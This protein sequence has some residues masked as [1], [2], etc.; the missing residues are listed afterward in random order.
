MCGGRGTRLGTETEKPLYPVRGRPM[1]DSVLG[2]LRESTIDDF[3]AVTS[4][5][6]P[7]TAAHVDCPTIETPGE[8]YVA[9][10]QRALADDRI[11]RPVLTVA[12]DL[13]LLDGVAVDAVLGAADGTL[14]VVVP[15]GRKRALGLSV[16]TQFRHGGVAVT[17]AGINVVGDGAETVWPTRD[18][19]YAVNVNRRTDARVAAWLTVDD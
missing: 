8:G 15:V 10:L 6:T 5:A 2:A 18:P 19:R 14:T 17:P 3:Y 9:D 1:V 4:P 12:T 16:D 13:P 11:S 7:A